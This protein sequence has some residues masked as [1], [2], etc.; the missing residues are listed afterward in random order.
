[1]ATETRTDLGVTQ[2]ARPAAAWL[3]AFIVVGC[4]LMAFAPNYHWRVFGALLEGLCMGIVA[5]PSFAIWVTAASVATPR[6]VTGVATLHSDNGVEHV[7][8]FLGVLADTR[9][10]PAQ[11]V[12]VALVLRVLPAEATVETFMRACRTDALWQA[13][14]AP[15]HARELEPFV[16]KLDTR[17][18]SLAPS[19]L[20]GRLFDGDHPLG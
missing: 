5:G 1:M 16:Q 19:S 11:R 2:L 4:T 9:L 17:L 12:A 10:T 6:S 18:E 7:V 13:G 8:D 3:C 15:E 20:Y 14:I